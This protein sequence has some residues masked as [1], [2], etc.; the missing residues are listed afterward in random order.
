MTPSEA[1]AAQ[2]REDP[3]PRPVEAL[4]EEKKQKE[5][6]ASRPG[7]FLVKAAVYSRSHRASDA[8]DRAQQGKKKK[9]IKA[10]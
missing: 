1:E 10:K 7:L 4:R 5:S 2:T 8:P 9:T 3:P 6:K